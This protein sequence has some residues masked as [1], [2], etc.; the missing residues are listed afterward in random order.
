MTR[1]RVLVGMSG[2]VDSSVAAALL[3]E[4][5]YAVH[6]VTMRIW[7]GA[8]GASA[9]ADPSPSGR[10]PHGCYGPGEEQEIAAA[11]AIAE[12]LGIPHAVIDLRRAY[13]EEV[14]THFCDQYRAGR[15]P[16]PCV[17]CN[18]RIKFG[19]LLT[20]AR[21]SG[22]ACDRFATGHYARITRAEVAGHFQL[23]KGYDRSKDQSY[24]L[25]GLSQ[26]QLA[27][28]LFPLGEQLKQEVRRHAAALDLPVADAAESQDFI[29]GD[30]GMLFD[31]PSPRGAIR[32]SA[33]RHL[34]EHRGIIHYTIGQRRGL[35]IAAAEP[36]YVIAIDA[37]RNTLIVGPQREL[38]RKRLLADDLVWITGDSPGL[39]LRARARIRYRHRE[40]SAWL[41]A[42]QDMSAS[43]DLGGVG[44]AESDRIAVEFDEPQSA[45]TPGQAVV[46]Y[47]AVEEDLVLGGGTIL[48]AL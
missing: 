19:A 46:F 13:H 14:L 27:E 43:A 5:G 1:L 26:S 41:R 31:S 4:Q 44:R 12:R 3:L 8:G 22:I 16:N 17:R 32:D 6:G 34:G 24:F 33:G 48:R 9:T 11:G 36:L 47:D 10:R 25:Y 40:A 7:G 42:P 35:G 37:G 29:G 21:R 28:T 23:R 20:E 45:I 39:P 2:G 18:P 15:T 30:W 38:L